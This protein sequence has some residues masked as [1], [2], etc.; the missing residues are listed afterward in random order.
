M[1]SWLVRDYSPDDLEAVVRVDAESGTTGEPA[2]FRLS[3]VVAALQAGHPAVVAVAGE[4]T[5]GAAVSRGDGDRAWILRICVH[6]SWRQQGLGSAL[7]TALEQR[8]FAGGVRTVHAVLPE[9][10]P[11]SPPCAT[12]PSRT[13]P[14][15]S[16][17]RNA[18]P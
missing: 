16:S 3:D 8:L 5:V 18:R 4:V 10:R 12:A 15:W 13:A 14:A 1:S 17:S 7:L 11:A 9:G 6:P 2:L